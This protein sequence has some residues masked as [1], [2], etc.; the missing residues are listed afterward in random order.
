MGVILEIVHDR[1]VV[2]SWVAGKAVGS[3]WLSAVG[4]F[5]IEE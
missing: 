1:G 2:E 4:M 3:Q 5:V